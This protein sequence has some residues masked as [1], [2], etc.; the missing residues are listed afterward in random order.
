MLRK[1]AREMAHGIAEHGKG[2]IANEPVASRLLSA[3]S[4]VGRAPFGNSNPTA[5]RRIPDGPLLPERHHA[6][7]N[8]PRLH[9]TSQR[10]SES[11]PGNK[12]GHHRKWQF[13]VPVMHDLPSS[14]EPTTAGPYALETVV[15]SPSS[16][17][18]PSSSGRSTRLRMRLHQA[19]PA[20]ERA[21]RNVLSGCQWWD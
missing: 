8:D 18:P 16:R 15:I 12:Q 14:S 21:H 13:A 3:G 17:C 19:R 9:R 7:K 10:G 6:P 2:A 1:T 4:G 11:I 20:E 5:S